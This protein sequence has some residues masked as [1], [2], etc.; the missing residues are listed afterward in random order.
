MPSKDQLLPI[1][2]GHPTPASAALHAI[3][4]SSKRCLPSGLQTPGVP[5][6]LLLAKN[7][8]WAEMLADLYCFLWTIQG[9]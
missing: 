1:S 4:I 7:S 5:R 9:L 2:H 6:S 8:S 3:L